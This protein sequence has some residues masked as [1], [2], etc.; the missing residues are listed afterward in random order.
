MYQLFKK[1]NFGHGEIVASSENIEDLEQNIVNILNVDNL[2][3]PLTLDEKMKNYTTIYPTIY[4]KSGNRYSGV[5]YS[6]IKNL[7]KHTFLVKRQGSKDL[8]EMNY[9]ELS[10]LLGVEFSVNFLLGYDKVSGDVVAVTPKGNA[11]TS[12]DNKDLDIKEREYLYIRQA[13]A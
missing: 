9:Q 8:E 7:N 13:N 12:F 11:I 6:G 4:D 5:F 2:D 1:D 3:N 10:T